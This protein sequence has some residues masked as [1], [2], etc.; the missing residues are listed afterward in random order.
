MNNEISLWSEYLT[1]ALTFN[2]LNIQPNTLKKEWT[3]GPLIY[4]YPFI[5]NYFIDAPEEHKLKM[6][7]HLLKYVVLPHGFTLL[8]KLV[9]TN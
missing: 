7:P 9:Y 4:V 8:S 5:I 6:L 1:H 2:T 3:I